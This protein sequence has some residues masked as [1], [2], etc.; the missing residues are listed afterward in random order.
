MEASESDGQKAGLRWHNIDEEALEYSRNPVAHTQTTS[1]QLSIHSAPSRRSS[2][3]PGTMLPIQYRTVSFNIDEAK[4]KSLADAKKAKDSATTELSSLEWH[5]LSPEEVC[6]R[7]STSTVKGLSEEEVRLRLVK[8]G[9]NTPSPPPT[10]RFKQ[11]FGYFFKG[12][13]SIL[14]LGSILVFICWKPL[15]EPP[16]QANLALAIVLLAVFFIQAAFNAWQDWSSSKVMASITNMMPEDCLLLRDAAQVTTAASGIVPG[17]LLLIKAGNKLPADV[18][19]VEISSDAKFDRSILTG[20]SLPLSGTVDST[21]DNYL[22]TK[23]I[24]MQG[25][26]CVSGSG[27]GVVVATGDKTVFG[28]IAKLTNEPKTG[29]TTLER[30]VLRFVVII[31]SIMLTMIVLVIILWAVW[32]RKDHPSWINV[33]TLIVDCVSVA[34]AFIPEGLPIALTASLTITANLM[35]KN[36]VLCKSLKTVETLGAVSVICSDKTGTLTKN[37]MSVTECSIGTKKMTPQSA[38]DEMI[39][40]RDNHNIST[41]AVDQLRA[42]A[43]LCN[44]GEFDAAT[45]NLPLQERK[46]NGDATDKA[47]L[48]F[49]EGLGSVSELRRFWKKT[50]ELAFNSKNKF[51][52]RTF[53]LADTEGL[54]YTLP[55]SEECHY[56]SEDLLLTIKGAPDVLIDRCTH[57]TSNSG[58]TTVL[59]SNIRSMIEGIKDDWSAHG[60]RVIL[61]ARKIIPAPPLGMSNDFESEITEN[62]KTGLTLVGL[63]SI[64]DPPR[65]EIPGVVRTLRGAGIRIFMVTGDFALTAQA[66]ATDCGIISN[67]PSLVKDF[68]ALSRDNDSQYG[69]TKEDFDPE[70]T[71]GLSSKTSIV[72]SGPEMITLN[73]NQWDQLCRYDEIVFARTTPEQKLRI[74]REFQARDEIVGMTG[75]GVND[76]PS[77]KA[78]DIGI[79]LGSGS[80]IAIEAADMVLLESFSAIVEAVQYGRVVFDNLKKTIAYL[81]PAGSFS[82]F[83]PVMTNV[84]FGLPQVLSSFLM[85]II[86]CFTDC[87]AATVLAYETPEADVLLRKPRNPRTDRLVDWRLILQSY[88]F[89]GVLETFS[90]FAMS[91]WYLQRSGIPFSALWFKYGAVPDNITEEYYSAR[92]AEASSIYFVNLV[93]MQWFSLMSLRTRRLSIFQHPP[94][95]NKRTQNLLLFPAIAFALCMAIF[96]LYIPQLQNVLA[97]SGVPAEH[98]FLPA[99]FGMGVLLLDEARK[100]MVRKWPRGVVAKFAW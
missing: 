55:L 39:K 84:L 96:W 28:R 66:I 35:R 8:Y 12:F 9:K 58:D 94:A 44:S 48:R 87:A 1:S 26:H 6:S 10:H 80:D 49:S 72:L 73:D 32:L 36:K 14:L 16:T 75:D 47:I 63:V 86:C 61:L 11:I 22:E 38:R 21:D 15:G 59:N 34:I 5:V 53:S 67:V 89:I 83:W 97:T 52:I 24:G 20:E 25:T 42:V 4:G 18:R 30:E 79:A 7:L 29:M 92:L 19:F 51:M 85:I 81:L 68:K 43:G 65:A 13:G 88:G 40:I 64:V 76:A 54:K 17:D 91:Y 23:C 100:F 3:D 74:V 33:P 31:V 95:F 78:A 98:F 27:L 46:I 56:S 77:L 70:T 50:F 2:I 99:A 62:V 45:G 57:F 90:S 69:S 82:E 37:E 41:N 93:V 60:K 71:H